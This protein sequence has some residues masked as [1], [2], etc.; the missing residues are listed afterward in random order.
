[1]L[2]ET[3]E[4]VCW[5]RSY[6]RQIRKYRQ[7]G[8]PIF[9]L[10]GTRVN[11]DTATTKSWV[12]TSILSARDAF[13]KGLST[14]IQNPSGKGKWLIIMHIGNENGFLQNGLCIFESKKE[15][16]YHKE[17][18]SETFEAWF[19]KDLQQLPANAVIVMDNT[20]YHS[21]LAEKIPNSSLKKDE[22]IK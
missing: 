10:D 11:V 12:D 17:M 7:K 3:N 15:G 14:G 22:M 13:S 6:L 20:L 16:D 19:S 5:R 9:S 2:I 21:H 8:R 1:M 18:T 4:I